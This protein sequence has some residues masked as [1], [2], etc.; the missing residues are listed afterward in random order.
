[1]SCVYYVLQVVMKVLLSLIQ[2]T[3]DKE[4]YFMQSVSIEAAL[5]LMVMC[6]AREFFKLGIKIFP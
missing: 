1:M 5:L 4:Q 3:N 6:F 2:V